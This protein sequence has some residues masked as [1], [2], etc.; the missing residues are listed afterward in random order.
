M[1][2]LYSNRHIF[3]TKC[4]RISILVVFIRFTSYTELFM[5]LHI[6]CCCWKVY[7]DVKIKVLEG[8]YLMK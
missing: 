4:N 8:R 7:T 3:H 6:P 5:Y 2:F 1:D